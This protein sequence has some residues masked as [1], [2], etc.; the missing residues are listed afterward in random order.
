MRPLRQLPLTFIRSHPVGFI[1]RC[2]SCFATS[3]A[4]HLSW[5]FVAVDIAVV[6][7]GVG[8]GIGS[9]KGF[10]YLSA[11]VCVCTWA[12]V[13]VRSCVFVNVCGPRLFVRGPGDPSGPSRLIGLPSNRRRG[14]VAT[15]AGD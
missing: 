5:S 15:D 10:V 14:S 1:L 6:N 3:A 8:R 12:R 11:C 13:Y 7:A 4:Y 9:F 2:R